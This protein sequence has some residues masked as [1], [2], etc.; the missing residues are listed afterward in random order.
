MKFCLVAPWHNPNRGGPEYNICKEIANLGISTFLITTD[1][2]LFDNVKYPLGWQ[3]TDNFTVYRAKKLFELHQGSFTVIN[4]KILEEIDPDVVL[5]IEYFQPFS[6]F[7]T[8]ICDELKIPFF[9]YQHMYRYPEGN[10][11]T[12]F[13]IYDRMIRKYVWNRTKKAIAISEQ[14]KQFLLNLGFKKQIE[15]IISG[16]DTKLFRPQKKGFLR[17][18][19]DLDD[20]FIV[21]CVARMCKEKGVLKIPFFARATEKLNIHYV[22]IGDGPL[23]NEF[24]KLSNGLENIHTI[25]FIPH[26]QL[27]KVYSDS[28]L[29][30]APS[31]VEVLNYSVLEAMACG[32]PV[33]I[34]DI[35]GMKE[36]VNKMIGF[37]MPK[38]DVDGWIKKIRQF[39][40]K[41]IFLDKKSI[42][43][44]SKL[45]AYEVVC[46]KL[47][48]TMEIDTTSDNELVI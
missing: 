33:I 27:P 38:D 46:K 5:S 37:L 31:N 44:H 13:R 36:L 23:K 24:E 15:T 11:G 4:K 16:V 43:N 32:L 30:I 1:N 20:E 40:F 22:V 17:D 35:G 7:A 21:L 9:F 34:S 29:Y 19:L 2:Y 14:A 39:Y 25:N 42:I 12:L 8:K 47:L 41:E 18:K 26:E 3:F 6:I 48:R 45:F 10:F 28:D